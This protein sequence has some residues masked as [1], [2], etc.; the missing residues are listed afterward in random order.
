GSFLRARV[1]HEYAET[2]AGWQAESSARNGRRA[3]AARS[4][5]GEM[6]LLRA[7]GS[8]LSHTRRP[9]DSPASPMLP[10][11]SSAETR[12]RRVRPLRRRLPELGSPGSGRRPAQAILSPV[13]P[14]SRALHSPVCDAAA[15]LPA[16]A[17]RI[18]EFR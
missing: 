7:R 2:P 18:K 3:G 5:A 8:A 4:R 16:A 13:E 15:K 6:N 9:P 12:P 1:A 14:H 17:P 11:A 10:P